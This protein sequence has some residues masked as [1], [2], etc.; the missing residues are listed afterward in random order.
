MH[1]VN[2]T[3]FNS[4]SAN[5]ATIQRASVDEKNILAAKISVSHPA[6][7]MKRLKSQGFGKTL[8]HLL[9]IWC[10]NSALPTLASNPTILLSAPADSI[11]CFWHIPATPMTADECIFLCNAFGFHTFSASVSFQIITAW[12][13][14]P[15]T[16]QVFSQGGKTMLLMIPFTWGLSSKKVTRAF[17]Q[18]TKRQ[19]SEVKLSKSGT[20]LLYACSIF[21]YPGAQE[22]L[23]KPQCNPHKIATINFESG[24]YP[25]CPI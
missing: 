5:K 12:S 13:L 11:I 22:M 3:G 8:M 16:K 15:V 1:K 6:W 7:T 17:C 19:E 18:C 20:A 9:S 2:K 4:R 23:L 21:V 10:L 25:L 14:P 24:P